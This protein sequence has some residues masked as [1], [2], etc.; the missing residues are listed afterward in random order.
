M[1]YKALCSVLGVAT[2]LMAASQPALSAETQIHIE[3]AGFEIPPLNDGISKGLP[4]WDLYGSPAAK[5]ALN[6][7]VI[8]YPAGAPEGYNVGVIGDGPAYT[9]M[10]QVLQGDTGKLLADATYTLRVHVGHPTDRDQNG[11]IIQLAAGGVVLAQD[12]NS[13]SPD[14]GSF[15]LTTITYTYNAALHSSLVGEPLEIRLLSKGLIDFDPFPLTTTTASTFDNVRLSVETDNAIADTGGPYRLSDGD[16]L[17]L[18]ASGSLPGQG[19]SSINSYEWDLDGDG[20]YETTPALATDPTLSNID[21]L[22]FGMTIGE[23][24]IGLKITDNNSNVATTTTT[25]TI[26]ALRTFT[27]P[28]TSRGG[29]RWNVDAYWNSGAGS[30][31]EGLVNVV[32]PDGKNTLAKDSQTPK[33]SGDLRLGVGSGLTSGWPYSRTVGSLNVLGTPGQTTIYMG[34]DSSYTTRVGED[35]T[36]PEIVLEGDGRFILGTS[37]GPGSKGN[38]DH[39]ISGP[40]TLILQGNRNESIANLNQINTFSALSAVSRVTV[41]ANAA[42]SLGTGNVSIGGQSDLVINA[43][44]AIDES[45]AL[46][47]DSS[48]STVLTLNSDAI[49]AQLIVNGS[50]YPAGT[51]GSSSSSAENQLPWIAGDNILTVTESPSTYLDINGDLA[52]S[53]ITNGALLSWGASSDWTTDSTGNS[54]TDSWVAG[55]TAAFAAGT[56]ANVNYT[57]SVGKP[58]GII[59]INTVT[60]SGSNG[61]SNLTHTEQGI[62]LGVDG[63][64]VVVQFSGKNI[65]TVSATFAGEPMTLV[66]AKFNSGNNYAGIAYI[67]DPVASSGDVEINASYSHPG[68][69][70]ILRYA[71]SISTLS[72]VSS[73]GTPTTFVQS[74]REATVDFTTTGNNGHAFGVATNNDWRTNDIDVIGTCSEYL[75]QGDPGYSQH[76]H[77]HGPVPLAGTYSDTYD[78]NPDVIVILPLGASATPNNGF[79]G[80]NITGLRFEDNGTVTLDGEPLNL[81]AANNV[82]TVTGGSTGDINTQLTGS[83]K[84]INKKGSGTLILSDTTNDYDGLTQVSAGTL[85]LGASNVIPN[86]SDVFIGGDT[87]GVTATLDLN[88]NSEDIT[89]LTFGGSTTTSAAAVT[90]GLGTLTLNGTLEYSG[91]FGALGSTISGKLVLT[92]PA[93]S[94]LVGDSGSA[95]NDL[96]IDAVIS[97]TGGITKNGYGTLLLSGNNTYTGAT[98]TE[99]GSL[100]FTGSDNSAA[101]GGITVNSGGIAGF[102]FPASIN[103]TGENLLINQNGL[104]YFEPGFSDLDGT[105]IAAALADRVD[106]ASTGV[107]AADNY[108]TTPFDF[109][110]NGLNVFLGAI[111]TLT[112]TGLITPNGTTYRIGG[113]PGA[114][115]LPNSPAVTGTDSVIIGGD[116]ILTGNNNSLTGTTT[117]SSGA[118]QIGDGGTTGSLA[119]SSITNNSVLVF[120]RSDAQDQGTDFLSPISGSGVVAQIGSGYLILD[121]ANTYSGGTTL[122]AGG[123]VIGDAAGIG[124]GP[125]SILAGTLDVSGGPITLSNNNDILLQGGLNYLGTADIDF[126]T[127]RLYNYGNHTITLGGSGRTFSAGIGSNQ[128]DVDQTLTV[129][130]AGNKLVLDGYELV[131]AIYDDFFEY[132]LTNASNTTLTIAGDADVDITGTIED[133]SDPLFFEYTLS[134]LVKAGTGTLTISGDNNYSGQTVV[135]SGILDVPAGTQI[136][137]F[138]VNAGGTLAL[139]LGTT[140]S[141]TGSLT[142]EPGHQIKV[143]LPFTPVAETEYVLMTAQSGVFALNPTL[144]SEIDVGGTNWILQVDGNDLKLVEEVPDIPVVIDIVDNKSGGPVVS[145][146]AVTYTI[147]FDRPL[148]AT[149]VNLGDFSNA[150]SATFTIDS[151]TSDTGTDSVF[152][153]QVTPTSAGTLQLRIPSGSTF[154][155]DPGSAAV[156]EANI[157]DNTIISVI[158]YWSEYN[159]W[160][161][162]NAFGTDSN[163][164][165][166][167]NGLAWILGADSVNSALGEL[168]P[169]IELDDI[170]KPDFVTFR[171]PLRRYAVDVGADPVTRYSSDLATW[172][173]ALESSPDVNITTFTDAIAPGIDRVEVDVR[174]SLAIDGKMFLQLWVMPPTAP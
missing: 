10:T 50:A 159:A 127:G 16:L 24:T 141:T 164:D 117:I 91:F 135:N 165:G 134:S 156:T 51:Y 89:N 109:S 38:F 129:N 7:D 70:N 39:P 111:D 35:I 42:G 29:E 23:N 107:V 85:Q 64:C 122:L 113:G 133:Y 169:E 149:T 101:T 34:Q 173:Q 43:T 112:Y 119:A 140:I 76:V 126:G 160:S 81:Q 143:H 110:D 2:L 44:G 65:G 52:G 20:S 106:A 37:T 100:I 57:V 121:N 170:D 75:Y 97:G 152:D 14:E 22:S 31:P 166:Y 47:I 104:V 108:T 83:G 86:T 153:V 3:N 172:T 157:D 174:R 79:S 102:G 5:A 163:G 55:S 72:G 19:G 68:G 138:L 171:F 168:V 30:I 80:Q 144:E 124:S 158:D 105:E 123:L 115:I 139:T 77:C 71:Y 56:D 95:T 145:G 87:A 28:N 98:S 12:D 32:I 99:D 132:W 125:L 93:H 49:C 63:N 90:T 92:D 116:V 151:V 18:D 48:A 128:S 41:N 114:L 27:G 26:F 74:V 142:L 6:P 120:N 61:T 82:M 17:N 46:S 161:D 36:F 162:N 147:T 136:S 146:E 1:N 88:D 167:A 69:N 15:V 59:K 13:K 67:I 33:Y 53:G 45:A 130:G 54:A 8:T 94:F 137:D 96:S 11:Y 21:P 154:T 78:S 40:H 155:P 60:G 103:G 131:T 62:D 148:N 58:A 66:G 73:A 150:G 25:V 4:H 9:G 84:G 118:L